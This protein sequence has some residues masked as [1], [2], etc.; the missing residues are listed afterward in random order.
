[1][2]IRLLTLTLLTVTTG[3]ASAA[4]LPFKAPPALAPVGMTWS[5]FYLGANA[6][7]GW[8]N[9][10]IDFSTAGLPAF[11]SVD[12]ELSGA[13]AGG[14][15]G[16]NWQSGAWVF[17]V[18]ADLQWSNMKGGLSAPCPPGF[19]AGLAAS[20][21]QKMPW[22]GTARGRLGYAA[23]GWMI[24]ATGGYAY[25]RV[26]THAFATAGGLVA[27]V[28]REDSRSGWTAGGGIEVAVSA[29]WSV[30]AEYLYLDFGS[31]DGSWTLTGLPVITDS[32]HLTT[33][34]ARGGVNYRF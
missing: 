2:R 18:E 24:Y 4:D 12:N 25:G 33:N 21:D 15:V 11:A 9:A 16:Y 5:G 22:F 32:T 26:E 7:G 27:D 17:G 29:N 30:K 3:T 1:M 19:C 10:G 6:G 34:I 31:R 14:Q 20:F 23:A 13:I 28:S 8:S